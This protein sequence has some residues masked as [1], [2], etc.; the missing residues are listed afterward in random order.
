MPASAQ[1]GVFSSWLSTMATPSSSSVQD[2]RQAKRRRTALNNDKDPETMSGATVQTSRSDKVWMADGNIILQSGDGTQFR[3]HKSVLALNSSFFRD[4]F[5]VV[6]GPQAD[7][8]GAT[9]HVDGCAVI[10]M[11]KDDRKMEWEEVLQLVYRSVQ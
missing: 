6:D 10:R 9:E 2:D 11:G 3:V 7:E 1:V 8:G 4:M 5:S